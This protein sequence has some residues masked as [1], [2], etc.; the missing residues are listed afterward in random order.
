MSSVNST[1]TTQQEYCIGYLPSKRKLEDYDHST[2]LNCNGKSVIDSDFGL[3]SLRDRFLFLGE[4]SQPRLQFFV[5]MISGSKNLVLR[6]NA[7]DTVES[8]FEKIE[9]ITGISMKD[10]RLLYKGK[11]LQ[12]EQTLRQCEIQNDAGLQLVGRM[13]STIYPRIWR[14][15]SDMV[16]II[17]RVCRKESSLADYHILK[18]YLYL[19]SKK[20][21]FDF[22]YNNEYN[23]KKLILIKKVDYCKIFMNSYAAQGLIMLYASKDKQYNH[24]IGA[25][26]CIMSF[27]DWMKDFEGCRDESERVYY[28]TTVLKLCN[29][30]KMVVSEEDH[31]YLHSRSSLG[32]MLKEVKVGSRQEESCEHVGTKGQVNRVAI[33]DL[34]PLLM[35][36]GQR[37]IS[38]LSMR[39]EPVY[40]VEFF[41]QDVRDF[42]SF[43]QPVLW[44]FS[45]PVTVEHCREYKS[46]LQLLF[47]DLLCNIEICLNDL[48]VYMVE[49]SKKDLKVNQSSGQ[50]LA[51]LQELASI[52][53]LNPD[54]KDKFWYIMR[55]NK[56]VLS[57]LVV[58]YATHA[59]KNGWLYFHNDVLNF[60]SRRHL[61]MLIF[62]DVNED[63]EELEMII[64]RSN[65]LAESF[66]YISGANPSSL[67]AGLYMEFK[68]ENATGPGVLR[69]WVSLVCQAIFDPENGLYVAC[70]L[71][72]RRFYPSAASKVDPLHL[73]YFQFSGRMI[74]LALMHKVQVG[75]ELDRSFIL[76]LSG[77]RVL[78]EDIRDADP[79]IYNSCK[80]ILEMDAEYVD[81]DGL[82]L[83]FITEVEELGTRKIVELCSGGESITVDSK[84]REEYINLIIQ[85]RFVTSINEQVI[86]FARGFDD[87]VSVGYFPIFFS[88]LE[89][90]DLDWMLRGSD[91]EICLE[92]WKSHTKYDGYKISDPQIVWFWEVVGE[93]NT[94]QK[95]TFLF[96]WT[97]IKFLPI[98]GFRGLESYLYIFKSLDSQVCLPTSHTCFYQLCIP[99]Y[100][101][102][103]VMRERLLLTTQEHVG[104]SF[105]TL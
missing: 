17:F 102:K 1:L 8:V 68:D 19:F 58:R 104:C 5:R 3:L 33:E 99:E 35:G 61:A 45:R 63:Y 47:N 97:S 81:S 94:E 23:I 87:I 77:R 44:F 25:S 32:S 43:L 100:P 98:E 51:I 67:Q 22:D 13:R 79:C 20:V 53:A 93:F 39:A 62:P 84:N 78:L 56:G 15:I 103:E 75:V 55:Q 64:D 60:E 50:Y 49:K 46:Q 82:G 90:E 65:L 10:Q 72:R 9:M 31:V 96:F 54:W 24:Y 34:F 11:Q 70:P 42:S 41:K 88:I 28:A 59:D 80:Q 40:S 92:D 27:V 52:S 85:H 37:L 83:T 18:V 95:K 91:C 89:P 16:S 29:M 30:L 36:I 101:S 21:R 57:D 74:A 105:G 76:Q 73:K 66:E 2:G 71:N 6:A 69:E 14:A 7:N 86:Y 38:Y 26:A 12:L 48:D 4:S